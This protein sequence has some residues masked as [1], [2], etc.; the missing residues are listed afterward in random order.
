MLTPR[1]G[2]SISFKTFRFFTI[3]QNDKKNAFEPTSWL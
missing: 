2:G 1:C 3:V